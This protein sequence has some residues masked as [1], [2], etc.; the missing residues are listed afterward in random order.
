MPPQNPA[1]IIECYILHS[2]GSLL[3]GYDGVHVETEATRGEAH[4]KSV[5]TEM[6]TVQMGNVS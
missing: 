2:A 5:V 6:L 3:H 1:V 4:V